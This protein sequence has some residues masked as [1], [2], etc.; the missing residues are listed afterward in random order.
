[1]QSS[2]D[3]NICNVLVVHAYIFCNRLVHDALEKDLKCHT[4]QRSGALPSSLLRWRLYHHV[5]IHWVW[6]YRR[7]KHVLDE[8]ALIN[9]LKGLLPIPEGLIDASFVHDEPPNFPYPVH[10]SSHFLVSIFTNDGLLRYGDDV[11]AP[12]P[13]QVLDHVAKHDFVRRP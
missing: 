11:G 9:L 7:C 12:N 2:G 4:H 1:M 13:F 8:R 10:V 5:I 3:G 6:F